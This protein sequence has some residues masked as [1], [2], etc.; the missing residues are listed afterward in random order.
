MSQK[1][2]GTQLYFIDPADDS[3][4]AVQCSTGISGFSA[5]RD[6]TEVTCLEDDSRSYEPGMRT[7]GP[8]T[9]NLNFD[10]AN[11]S[12]LR[13]HQLYISGERSVE[14]ALG[15]G[16]GTAAPT[17]DTAGDFI[18]PA[19]RTFSAFNG[20]FVDVPL[21]FALSSVVT[22][23]VTIQVSGDIEIVPKTP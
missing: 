16:D 22:A 1:T 21:E 13:I 3:V 6:S 17:V 19:T 11:V 7:P 8:I 23:A 2:Q 20:F 12:H 4:V 14:F 5:P 18:L 15:W 10:P 9:L